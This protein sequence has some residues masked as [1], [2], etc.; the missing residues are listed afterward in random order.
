MGLFGTVVLL[1]KCLTKAVCQEVPRQTRTTKRVPAWRVPMGPTQRGAPERVSP[2][3]AMEMESS[4]TSRAT[5]SVVGWD[6]VSVQAGWHD[7]DAALVSR[8]SPAMGAGGHPLH[9]K[10]VTL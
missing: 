2:E 6:M 1:Q 3:G 5:K 4:W 7:H 9:P 8:G 10:E